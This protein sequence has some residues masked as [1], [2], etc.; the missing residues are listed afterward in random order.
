MALLTGNFTMT[1]NAQQL[2][3][4]TSKLA[5]ALPPGTFLSPCSIHLALAL[6]ASGATGQ[7]LALLYSTAST[8]KFAIPHV[9]GKTR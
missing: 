6:V 4:L 3:L 7:T 5:S 1:T 8:T 2:S 9:R